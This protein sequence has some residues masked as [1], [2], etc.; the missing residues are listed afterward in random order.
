METFWQDLRHT[1]RNLLQAPGFTLVAALTLAI[2]IGANTAVFSIINAILLRPLQFRAP[3]ELVRL[4]ETESAPGNY[5]FAGPDF[6]DW[7]AQNSTFQD[8][9]LYGW[10]NDFNLSGSGSP[11]HILG[12][13]TAANF[14][15]LLGVQPLLGRTWT[16]R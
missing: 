5:P 14:F 11:D 4:Y 9:A 15:S 1:V 8:M 7:K 16:R 3:D 13:P 10:G 12:V 6:V 2:G